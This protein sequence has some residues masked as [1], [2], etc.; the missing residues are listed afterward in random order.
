MECYT[1]LR[2]VTDLCSDGKTPY[3]RR[4]GQPLKGPIIPFGSL[5]EYHPITAKDQSRIHQFGKNV[6][7]GLFLGYALYAGGIW[8]GD[9]LIADL[10]ELETMNASE[11]Y[12]ERLNAKEVIFPKQ[13]EFIFPIADWRIKIP[14]G[15]QELRISTLIRPRPIQGEGHVFSWRIRR[16]SSTTS[17]LTSGCRWSY[18]RLLVHVGQLHIPPSRWTTSRTLLAERRIIP[19]STEV[20]WRHQNY[21]Y[22][23]GCQARE[24]HRWLLEYWWLSR[25]V[26]SL[27][28]FH[29]MNSARWKSSWRIYLVR[30]EIDERTAY[31]QARSSMARGMEV[32]G[33]EHQAE[34]KAKMVLRKDSSRQRTK[35][36]RNSW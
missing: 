3:E 28:R 34:G 4:F 30:G 7:P 25:L 19:Y 26:W 8:K 11:I 33:K 32:N 17:W 15:D 23:F 20:H 9:V 14:G 18:A 6:L 2:N 10:D 5:V 12:S 1:Y 35:I 24:A 29:T 36:A 21:S 22:E 31:I 27:D 16:F 13:G